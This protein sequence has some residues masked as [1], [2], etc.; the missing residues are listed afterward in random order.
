[1]KYHQLRVVAKG[2]DFI[3]LNRN[4]SISIN[5]EF[6]REFETISIASRGDY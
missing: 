6:G 3:V 5:N 2:N 4:G 1:M